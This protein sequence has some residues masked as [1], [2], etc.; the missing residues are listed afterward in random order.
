MKR[1]G[2]T[3]GRLAR[4][5]GVH[6]ETVRYYQRIG[7]ITEP[8]RPLAGFRCYAPE[9]VARVHFIKRAQRLGFSL[10][11]IAD[12]LELGDG[13]CP[14]VRERAEEKRAQIDVQI[15]DLQALR[16]TLDTLI[17]A[18]R[19]GKDASRCPIVQT[20]AGKRPPSGRGRRRP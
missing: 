13:R 16:G 20:L 15:R 5:A 18:C 11:D 2:L 19:A 7:L 17:R 9:T 10:K 8:S 1:T 4:E 12:L 3:I 6:V 14:D